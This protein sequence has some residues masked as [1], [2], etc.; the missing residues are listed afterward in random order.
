MAGRAVGGKGD[1][2]E[3]GLLLEPGFLPGIRPS[4]MG[5]VWGAHLREQEQ[6]WRE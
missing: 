6:G 5:F 4:M 3:Q 1:R 2:K